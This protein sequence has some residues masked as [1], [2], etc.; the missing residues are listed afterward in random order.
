MSARL[1]DFGAY[2]FWFFGYI[3][4]VSLVSAGFA[5]VSDIAFIEWVKA[6]RWLLAAVWFGAMLCFE[7]RLRI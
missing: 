3:A 4:F 2:M 5:Y 7:K 6:L 1:R